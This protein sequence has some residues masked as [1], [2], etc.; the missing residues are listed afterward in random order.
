MG[1]LKEMA[2]TDIVPPVA[3]YLVRGT[4]IATGAEAGDEKGWGLR[5]VVG[6]AADIETKS[7]SKGKMK[8]K[9]GAIDITRGA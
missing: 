4:T 8:E 2:A 5:A 6:R 7:I 3:G 1:W 9:Q